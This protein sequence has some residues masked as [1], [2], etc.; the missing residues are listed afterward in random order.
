ML[1]HRRHKGV[2]AV[3]YGVCLTFQRIVK[4]NG[5]TPDMEELQKRAEALLPEEFLDLI[6]E[7]EKAVKES[8]ATATD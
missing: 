8:G 3:A 5:L 1:H 4:E 2:T 7:F 6:R